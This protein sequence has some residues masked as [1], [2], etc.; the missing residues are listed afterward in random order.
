MLDESVIVNIIVV[1][2]LVSRRKQNL[3]G[4]GQKFLQLHQ[5]SSLEL[6]TF[7]TLRRYS[8]NVKNMIAKK[9]KPELRKRERRAKRN[10]KITEQQLRVKSKASP[11]RD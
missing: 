9:N 2:D 11:K 4:L 6:K 10:R 7:S 3:T 8:N 1:T 5:N